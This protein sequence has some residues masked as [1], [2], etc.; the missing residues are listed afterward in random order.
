MVRRTAG[1]ES[2]TFWSG[3]KSTTRCFSYKEIWKRSCPWPMLEMNNLPRIF[4]NS[5][6]PPLRIKCSITK[7]PLHRRLDSERSFDE[8]GILHHPPV[9]EGIFSSYPS[10][11]MAMVTDEW[12]I[13]S[14]SFDKKNLLLK[15]A[16][17][18]PPLNKMVVDN[19]TTTATRHCLND[20]WI[21]RSQKYFKKFPSVFSA[22]F[23]PRLSYP[24]P[25]PLS[26]SQVDCIDPTLIFIDL[27]T[28]YTVSFSHLSLFLCQFRNYRI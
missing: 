7:Y 12:K 28:L 1:I 26:H 15:C 5:P 25:P 19:I 18:P 10:R 11:L 6:P 8:C 13:F 3:V 14:R 22:V 27:R 24:P 2:A 23:A 4:F 20:I 9:Y 21:H 16:D 17:P